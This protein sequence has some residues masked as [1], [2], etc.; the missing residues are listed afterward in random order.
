MQKEASNIQP[1]DLLDLEGDQYADSNDDDPILRY[2]HAVVTN[3]EQET[4]DCVRID[5]QHGSYGFPTDHKIRVVG[6]VTA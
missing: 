1:N 5:T 4:I 6:R 2:E 3:T